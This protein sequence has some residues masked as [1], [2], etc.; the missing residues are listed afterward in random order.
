MRS[1][2]MRVQNGDGPRVAHL[3]LGTTLHTVRFH[4]ISPSGF[5]RICSIPFSMSSDLVNMTG[6]EVGIDRMALQEYH[7]Q[8]YLGRSEPWTRS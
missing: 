5:H 2:G 8:H 7:M 6:A 3:S 1:V 4:T